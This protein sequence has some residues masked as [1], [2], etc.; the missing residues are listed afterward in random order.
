MTLTGLHDH[1]NLS[2]DK[3]YILL[4]KKNLK[5]IFKATAPP[6]NWKRHTIATPQTFQ[7]GFQLPSKLSTTPASVTSPG[8]SSMAIP[9]VPYF[10]S[11]TLPTSSVPGLSPTVSSALEPVQSVEIPTPPMPPTTTGPVYLYYMGGRES[12]SSYAP[13]SSLSSSGSLEPPTTPVAESS[14]AYASRPTTA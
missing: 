2:T 8:Y 14:M 10:Y 3:S 13:S 6:G 4:K 11:S 5:K 12:S 1:T 9:I 7:R